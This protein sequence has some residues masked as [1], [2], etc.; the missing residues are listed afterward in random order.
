MRETVI[1]P[2][3]TMGTGEYR[4]TCLHCGQLFPNQKHA[5]EADR[6]G[7]PNCRRKHQVELTRRMPENHKESVQTTLF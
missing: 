4:W 2:P 5:Q 7:C 3:N 1:I 6:W